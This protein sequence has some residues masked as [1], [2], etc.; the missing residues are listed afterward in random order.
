MYRLPLLLGRDAGKNA[1]GYVA[2]CQA[3][4]VPRYMTLTCRWVQA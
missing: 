3:Q 4:H 1:V 2:A